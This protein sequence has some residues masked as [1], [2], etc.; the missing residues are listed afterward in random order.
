MKEVHI[1]HLG[2]LNNSKDTLDQ[3]WATLFGLRAKMETKMVYVGQYNKY[4]MDLNDLNF[5]RKRA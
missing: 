2:N 3:G 1:A 5:E 4:Y